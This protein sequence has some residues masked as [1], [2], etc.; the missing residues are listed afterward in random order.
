MRLYLITGFLGAGK[1]TFLQ[2]FIKQ[3]SDKRLHIIINEFGKT[4]VDGTLFQS[5]GACLDEINNGSIMCSCRLDKFY[6]TLLKAQSQN[7]EMILVEASGLTDPTNVAAVLNDPK[8][9]GIIYMGSICLVDAVRFEKVFDTARAVKKQLCASSVA[10]V[11][12]CD[13]VTQQQKEK[14]KRMV[15]DINP[16]IHVAFTEFGAMDSGLMEHI[17]P[18]RQLVQAELSPDITLQKAQIVLKN[19]TDEHL[20]ISILTILCRESYRL[21]GFIEINSRMMLVDCVTADIKISAY[22]NAVPEND[23]NKLIVLAGKGMAL[24]AAIKSVKQLYP[25]YIE[26]TE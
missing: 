21:K 24:R 26:K 25:N 14:I 15:V 23:K 4:G 12:K 7:P 3:N 5:V 9:G 18:L 6:E 16:S 1:T 10:L 22:Q 8:F 17:K 20:L 13:L 2:K 11:N 19:I